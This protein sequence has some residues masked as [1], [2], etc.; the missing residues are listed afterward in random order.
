MNALQLIQA[1]VEPGD[2]SVH[3]AFSKL[4][5]ICLD[6]GD[7]GHRLTVSGISYTLHARPRASASLPPQLLLTKSSD[8]GDDRKR[9]AVIMNY[10][11]EVYIY[12]AGENRRISPQSLETDALKPNTTNPHDLVKQ[13]AALYIK[14]PDH[15]HAA[16]E[17]APL[18][19]LH[20]AGLSWWGSH[21]FFIN[22]PKLFKVNGVELGAFG[23][24]LTAR[25]HLSIRAGAS[26]DAPELRFTVRTI[27]RKRTIEV[28]YAR[29][30]GNL[31]AEKM[32][33]RVPE[34]LVYPVRNEAELLKALCGI[35]DKRGSLVINRLVDKPATAAAEPEKNFDVNG[36]LTALYDLV[37]RKGHG[38]HR[39][40]LGKHV[41]CMN[42][43]SLHRKELPVAINVLAYETGNNLA[44]CKYVLELKDS[45]I[46]LSSSTSAWARRYET[47]SAKQL[48]QQILK[49]IVEEMTARYA[50]AATRR[51]GG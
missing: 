7:A 12:L 44:A 23:P 26:Q 34:A 39:F 2:N 6:A 37:E 45:R 3:S 4:Y 33:C 18:N 1:A 41:I 11:N 25:H 10:Q 20:G 27:V 14:N 35:R 43:I 5:R 13:A 8:I 21:K 51:Y 48:L 17:P 38:T 42:A 49:D 15:V 32:L 16:T 28:T 31:Q 50:K 9:R 30:A 40:V 19:D 24:P 46:D 36:V 47:G 22:R 29:V